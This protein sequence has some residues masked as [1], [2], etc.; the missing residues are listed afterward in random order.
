MYF[1]SILIPN[2]NHSKYLIQRIDSVLNQSYQN[3]E[4]IILDDCSTDNSRNIIEQY[5]NH[6][7]VSSIIFNQQNSGSTFE[8]WDKGITLAKGE[9]IWIAESDDYASPLFLETLIGFVEK[10]TNVTLAYC[11][12]NLVDENGINIGKAI[13][14]IDFNDKAYYINTGIQECKNAFFFQPIIPNSSAV[15]FKKDAFL[16]VSDSFK[17]YNTCG[18]W[19]FWSD[20]AFQGNLIYLPVLLNNFR[21]TST[22]VSRSTT[23]KP[24]IRRIFLLEKLRVASYIKLKLNNAISFKKSAKFCDA[25]LYEILVDIFNGTVSL[26]NKDRRILWQQL[27]TINSFFWLFFIKAIVD[28]LYDSTKKRFSTLIK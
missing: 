17:T 8:Q 3:F 13:R 7:K 9:Y 2:Y 1:V 26:S 18:D 21:Q 20:I 16:N 24:D 19:Q 4:V 22:S 25:Y 10:H 27:Y 12:S 15:I 28:I 23:Y 6:P 11:A 14:D 5:Q